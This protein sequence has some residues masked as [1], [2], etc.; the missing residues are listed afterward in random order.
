LLNISAAAHTVKPFLPACPLFRKF[1]EPD[2][3]AKLQDAN[4]DTTA[5]LIGID[6]ESLRTAHH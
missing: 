6:I 1:S 3:P 2:K 4:I 5:T